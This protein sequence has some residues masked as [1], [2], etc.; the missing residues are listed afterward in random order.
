MNRRPP[1]P[2]IRALRSEVGFGCPVEGCGSPYLEWHHFDP[3]WHV[4]QHHR[5]EGMIALCTAHHPMADGGAYTVEQL[6]AFK[7]NRVNAEAVRGRFAWLR[8]KLL[9]VIGGNFYYETNTILTI[10]GVDV[11]YFTR[12]D[13][14][15]LRLSVHMLSLLSEQRA[16]LEESIWTNIGNPSDINSP[17]SGKEL[18]IKYANGDYLFVKFLEIS[19]AGEAQKKY[20]G[21]LAEFNKFEYPITVVEVNYEV[22][23]TRIKFTPKETT[24]G[25][26]IMK[27]C[28]VSYARTAI[29]VRFPEYK[30]RQNPSEFASANCGRNERCPC[31]SGIRFKHCHGNLKY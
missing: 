17:P 7:Q 27:E 2:V 12:D 30:F 21:N 6:R 13:D 1:V 28:F 10:D 5:P 14:G 15:Y 20:G 3:P 19:N 24:I 23:N 26:I 11:I 8:N 18:E 29:S 4:E 16:I 31:G 22:A 9:A 25:G